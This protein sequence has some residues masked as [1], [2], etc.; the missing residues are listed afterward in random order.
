MRNNDAQL[1]EI[2]FWINDFVRRSFLA[3]SLLLGVMIIS[4][5][6][7][8]VIPGDPARVILGINATEESVDRLRHTLGYDRPLLEQW[9]TYLQ[10][11]T[12][13]DLGQSI[14]D[15]RSVLE[16]VSDKFTVSGK[17]G[18]LGAMFAL[19]VSYLVN[20]LVYFCPR[21]NR[22]VDLLNFGIAVPTFFSG[23]LAALIFGVWL[24]IVPLTSDGTKLYP[25]LLPAYVASLYPIA[26]MTSLL[27]TKLTWAA[28]N[29]FAQAASAFGFSR[30][31]M[32][33]KTL[34]RPVMISWLS[35][36][37]NQISLIFVASFVLEVIFTIPGVG[38]LLVSSIQRKDYPMLQGVL[39]FNA[40]F[41]ILLSWIADG[42][43]SWLDIRIR[44]HAA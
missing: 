18:F 15:G 9:V 27:R 13:L 44:H 14:I 42:L 10:H 39:L 36:W 31:H 24:P 6:L 33:H 30:W 4:F 8:N 29:N 26:L 35:A 34:L 1:R 23:V 25:L 16:E 40:F 3:L 41:F 43:F 11:V 19:T 5:L 22:L 20:L 38:P 17:V 37:V 28:Q 7:F 21:T 2:Q 12:K 32:F